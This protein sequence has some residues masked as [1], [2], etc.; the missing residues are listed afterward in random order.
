MC[1]RSQDNRQVVTTGSAEG[2]AKAGA[3]SPSA[4]SNDEAAQWRQALVGV[5]TVCSC[6]SETTRGAT[7][8]V[9]ELHAVHQ[10]LRLEVAR[11]KKQAD[12]VAA[13]AASA[14]AAGAGATGARVMSP[15]RHST[16]VDAGNVLFHCVDILKHMVRA[17]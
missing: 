4:L 3:G 2:Y 8:V 9:A 12:R 11:S 1:H 16:T 15:R 17:C 13:A 10:L 14:A 7:V 5:L 6:V